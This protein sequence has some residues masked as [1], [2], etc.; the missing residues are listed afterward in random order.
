M[1]LQNILDG[2]ASLEKYKVLFYDQFLADIDVDDRREL[3]GVI[4]ESLSI[5][6]DLLDVAEC[7]RKL[8]NEQDRYSSD[9]LQRAMDR[10][11]GLD[12]RDESLNGKGGPAKAR[13]ILFGSKLKTRPFGTISLGKS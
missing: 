6:S 12:A 5:I 13:V 2:V 9:E 7:A 1:S 8:L 3:L 4:N 10:I 11:S